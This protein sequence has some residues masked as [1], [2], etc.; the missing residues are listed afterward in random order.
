M[1]RT[2]TEQIL[3]GTAG[4]YVDRSVDRAYVHDGT[5][6]LT[7][8]AFKEMGVPLGID[9]SRI[10]V[11]YD[12]ICPANT[13]LTADL[14]KELRSFAKEQSIP[15]SDCGGGICHQVMS[16]GCILPGEVVVGADSHS[17][18][19]GAFG[20]FATGVGAT[21][22]AAIWASGETWFRVPETIGISLNRSLRGAAEAKDIALSVAARLGMEGATYCA[23]EYTGDGVPSL[24]M[25]SRLCIC[26]MGIETGAKNAIFYADDICRT[27]LGQFGHRIAPQIPEDCGYREEIVLDLDD[28]VPV[29][30]LPHRVDT[31]SPV[32]E[33][34]G[35]EVDQVLLGT[36][37]NGRYSDL[38]RFSRLVR[39]KRV[40]VR[41]IVV[42]A[43]KAVLLQASRDG[44]ISDLIEAG[45][46][47]VSPGCG[48]C[49]GMHSGVLGDGDVCLSTANRN[50]KNR[51]GVGGTIY[52]ASPATAAATA[53]EGCIADPEVHYA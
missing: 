12:H 7:L 9:V 30:A 11:L 1:S 25:E 22:M 24:D 51:M 19:G 20:A 5:G 18:T 49:L 13:G 36:C 42:P 31:I 3:G 2:L 47:I 37:T 27:Y 46:I 17:C 23:L 26:N 40:R 41:T 45:C 43:S 4:E 10:A 39:G 32:T 16:E 35:I 21:D 33:C 34:T 29:V 52:L 38:L 48:P 50:F 6:V 53:L 44:I 14:Q 28:I 15:F 8:Q